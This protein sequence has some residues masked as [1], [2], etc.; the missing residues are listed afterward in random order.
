[1]KTII[2]TI[3]FCLITTLATATPLTYEICAPNTWIGTV[4]WESE[5]GQNVKYKSRE[6]LKLQTIG[7]KT[8]E[9]EPGWYGVTVYD[10]KNNR[11]LY[12]ISIE[13]KNNPIVLQ[14]GCK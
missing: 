10:P 6:D 2:L 8:F 3:L 9:V 7:K 13:V 12:Y 11:I 14:W 1:M 4:E 5:P